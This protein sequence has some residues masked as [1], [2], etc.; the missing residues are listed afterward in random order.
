MFSL[1]TEVG[2]EFDE[3]L[4]NLTKTENKIEIEAKAYTTK[5]TTEIIATCAFGIKGNCIE[6]EKS[7]FL[8][9]GQK[10]FDFTPA[11]AFEFGTTFFMPKVAKFFRHRVHIFL[12]SYDSINYFYNSILFISSAT[13]KGCGSIYKKCN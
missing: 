2:E 3:H 10:M 7:G 12:N 13:H 6:N 11:R 5:Y 8:E 4:K 1:I 9:T